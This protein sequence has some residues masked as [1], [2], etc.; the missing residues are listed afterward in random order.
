MNPEFLDGVADLGKWYFAE[1]PVTTMVWPDEVKILPAGRGQA[2]NLKAGR[3]RSGARVA[4]NEKNI[5][6]LPK[7][8]EVR[9]I[10]AS[11]PKKAWKRYTIKEGAKGPI[12]ADFAFVRAISQRG[13][14]PGHEIWVIFR[15]SISDPTEIKYFLSN[16]PAKV[17]KTDLVRQA[18]LRWP[19]ETALE[20]GKS[21]LGMDHYETRTWLGWHHH[22]TLTFLAHHFLVRLRLKVKKTSGTDSFT[23]Q[24]ADAQRARV[25]RT[26][27]QARA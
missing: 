22:M 26:R 1:V 6:L 20:E 23:K 12:A 3:P 13:R 8:Q 7:P 24:S 25:A 16:A 17:A 2:G 11:L 10:G 4:R 5:I 15:R 27:L 21:E 19:V 9:Q 18:G 14:R